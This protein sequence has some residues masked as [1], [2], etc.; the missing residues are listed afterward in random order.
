MKKYESYKTI[1]LPWLEKIPEHWKIFRNKNIF[2]ESKETVGENFSQYTL[3]SLTL[4]GI[5]PRDVESGK[6]K[7]PQS[8]DTYT[9]KPHYKSRLP[10]WLLRSKR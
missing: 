10:D 2:E 5:I 9:P 8:F 3:L 7:F 6:G 1:G 4:N